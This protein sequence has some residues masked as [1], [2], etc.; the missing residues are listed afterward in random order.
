MHVKYFLL[1][2]PLGG[3]A[4]LKCS[5]STFA[6]L[7]PSNA[8]L[9]FA[10]PVAQNAS[11]GG[12]VQNPEFPSPAINLPALCAVS[13]NVKSSNSS[14]F[15]F[16][17][18]LPD[19]WNDRTI[20]T[21]NGGF[22]G[23]INWPDMGRFSHYGFAAL[24]TD[25]GH[26]S[27]A[28]DGSWAL[29]DAETRT[30]WGYRAMHSSVQLGRQLTEAYYGGNSSI[31]HSYYSSCSTGGRQGLKELQMF[32]EDF[33]GVLAGAPA[34]WTTHLQTWTVHIGLQNLPSIG[35]GYIPASLFPT[36][37]A[38]I[39]RQCD[40]QDGVKDNI[41]SDPY[42]CNFY[43]EAL[44]CG[45]NTTSC[46]TTPQIQTLYQIYNDWVDTNQTFV[47]PNFALGADPTALAGTGSI[48]PLGSAYVQ[49]FLLNDPTWDP[50]ALDY[51]TVQLADRIDPG[52][53]NAD[54]FDLSAFHAR[55]GKLIT[56]HGLIDELIPTGSSTYY[57]KRVLETM[58]PKGVALDDFFRLFLI[59]G[60][61]HCAGGEVAP[62]YIA[63]AI[64]DVNGTDYSVPGFMDA[65]HDAVLAM[66]A[67]VENGT[68][69]AEIVATK[70]V[71][72]DVRKGVERQR[73]LC[74][75]PKMARWDGVGDVDIA[76]SW[77]CKEVWKE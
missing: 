73:P 32:P 38:E 9:N 18:F 29:N 71:G 14:S 53:A 44:L 17:L 69:P 57:Y 48:S 23:G 54:S 58:A 45:G 33:D 30:D 56:Y 64:Q 3:M 42:G 7:L 68:A 8:S 22:G 31:K 76:E 51:S 67:W 61:H 2:S 43:P 55:G 13:V 35:D 21:G 75:Y 62:W 59:P 15:N 16:G 39:T 28:S 6:A 12:G 72:D 65:R 27:N 10:T 49:D 50:L 4:A 77:S 34:W 20:A 74:V 47:F 19:S 1:Y 37:L 66:M 60:M 40:P 52:N 46:L 63:G 26:I 41:I 24:S 70:F 36:V 5:N 25:T 11:F